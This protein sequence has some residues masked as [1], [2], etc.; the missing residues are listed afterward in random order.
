MHSFCIGLPGSPDLAAAQDVANFLGTKH[1][2]FTFTVEEGLDAIFDV[3][4]HLETYD[5]TTV[6][7]STPMYLLSRKI[8][9]LGVK[10]VLSGEGSDEIFGGYLYFHNA[11]SAQA[12]HHECITRVQN[13]HTSDNLRANKSTMAWG[14][15]ARVPFLDREFLDVAMSVDANRKVVGK[16]PYNQKMEKHLLRKAFDTPENPYLPE[17]VLWRQKEQFSDGVGYS[18]IDG[19]KD[20]A[21]KSVS[22]EQMSNAAVRYPHDTPTTK[23][24][25]FI[26]DIFEQHFPQKA[27]L[28]SVVRWIPRKDWGEL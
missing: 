24:A 10:M 27:C 15:E 19:I 7:A 6:R 12:L 22:D 26:R 1:H 9:A 20:H 28:E 3:I 23:E 17:N 8:K 18:W 13:L 11:P 21:E 2:A 25:Y 16:P 5:V 4:Y 14:L